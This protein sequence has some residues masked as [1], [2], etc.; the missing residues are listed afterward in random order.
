M[1]FPDIPD[2]EPDIDL[3]PGQMAELLVSSIAMEE[4]SIA[5]VMEA[6][7]E[8]IHA[9]VE[10]FRQER[11]DLSEL[12]SVNQSA[13]DMVK[14]LVKLEMLLQWKLEGVSQLWPGGLEKPEQE[15]G[16]ERRPCG[17]TGPRPGMTPMPGGNRPC[18]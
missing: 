16:P 14:T 9:A 10:A 5:Q 2:I 8:K 18:R 7:K 3:E 17:G 12:L 15:P 6:E 13:A 4:M 11:C 1:S